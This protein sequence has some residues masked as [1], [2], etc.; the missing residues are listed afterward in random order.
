M[1]RHVA[2]PVHA[3]EPR[4][5]TT[6][7]FVARVAAQRVERL[8]RGDADPAPLAGRVAP[9]AVVP[10][11]LDAVLVDDR[12]VGRLEP[13][14]LEEGAV[15]VAGEEARLLAL[16]PLGD[17]EPCGGCLG[18]RLG[19]RQLAERELDPLEL[20]RVE[21]GEHVGLVLVR[22]G[23]AGEQ[24]AAVALD[25]PRV[26]AR[27]ELRG[28]CALGEREQL[29][30]PEAAVATAARVRRLAARV[31]GDERVDDCAAELLAEVER[32]VRQARA[33]GRSRAPRSRLPASSRRAPSRAPSGSSQSRS[34]TPI[35]LRAGAEERDRAVDAAAH[36]DRDPLGV[37]SRP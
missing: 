12:P 37:G 7:V 8:G 22:I 14:A 21:R 13:A 19:L 32:H 18:T 5:P 30:E 4:G 27:P 15:V 17:R 25:D 20:R 1:P 33:R 34:V 6:S 26:V 23:G 9:E 3:S 11:E 24:P 29:V 16:A 36:R 31:R 28:A 2:R 10:A 35:A